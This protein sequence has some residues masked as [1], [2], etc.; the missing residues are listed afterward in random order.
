MDTGYDSTKV[1]MESFCLFLFLWV[2]NFGETKD[3]FCAL[4]TFSTS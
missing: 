4:N 2:T 1:N 3:H